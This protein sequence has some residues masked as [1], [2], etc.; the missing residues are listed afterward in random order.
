[1]RHSSVPRSSCGCLMPLSSL[2]LL[3]ACQ[4]SLGSTSTVGQGDDAGIRIIDAAADGAI[5][6]DAASL[7]R[8]AAMIPRI[9]G[10]VM[11]PDGD[12]V[13][14]VTGK[15]ARIT[16][17][18]DDGLTFPF[19]RSDDDGASC[20][21]IDCDHHPGSATGL[22]FGGGDVYASFGWG[23]YPTRVMRSS[24]GTHWETV[25]TMSGFAFAGL[26][27]AGDRLIGAEATPRYSTD[28]G[29]TFRMAAWPDYR[30]AEGMWPNARRVGFADFDGG[31]IALISGNG[32]GSWGDTTIS[33][34]Q[35]LTYRHPTTLPEP[36]RGHSREMAYGGGVW[37]QAWGN[38]GVV[39]RSTD[40]GDH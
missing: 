21:G 32:D 15:F 14:V 39:C 34:D 37:I 40:D 30:I 8:D 2:A 19:D 6:D 1:M 11:I 7:E 23:S 3:V 28:R 33:R 36:C 17:S 31:R 26:V 20:T 18:C 24:D 16:T 9:D 4:G 25:F 38:T 5:P 22:T 27:W 13:F 29:M 12:P 35:G 10:G